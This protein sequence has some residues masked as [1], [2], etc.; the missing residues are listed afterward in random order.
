MLEAP[1]SRRL[2][3]GGGTELLVNPLGGQARL[4]RRVLLRRED[5]CLL[6]KEMRD[7]VVAE[8]AQGPGR[9]VFG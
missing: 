9:M 7:R 8:E 4:E 2:R 6:L 1:S 5:L 3:G